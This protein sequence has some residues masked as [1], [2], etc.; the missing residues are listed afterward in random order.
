MAYVYTHQKADFH[1]YTNY[2]FDEPDPTASVTHA[3][4]RAVLTLGYR[5]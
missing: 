4:N 1:P 2:V 5:F 3:N